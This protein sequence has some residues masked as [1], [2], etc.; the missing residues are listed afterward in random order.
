MELPVDEEDN[1]KVVRVPKSLEMSATAFLH[2]EESHDTQTGCHD[3]PSNT[4]TSGE[5]GKKENDDF[6]A[7][8]GGL[9]YCKFC[10]V[11]HMGNNVND[12]K[13]HDG[14]TGRLVKGDGL[15]EGDKIVQWRAT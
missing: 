6:I 5:I 1:E 13:N 9:R 8:F 15:V 10:K 3:P 14:P 2:G 12:G 7:G 11:D 4:R